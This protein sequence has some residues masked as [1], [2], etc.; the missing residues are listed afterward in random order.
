MF[1]R[2]PSITARLVL[3][4]LVSVGLMTLD[5]R[6]GVLQPVRYTLSALIYPVHLTAELPSMVQRLFA[7]EV[8]DRRD[9]LAEIDRLRDKLLLNRARLQKLD[10]L[11]VENIRLRKLL[12]ASY[13]VGES[14]LIAE[15]M[16][17]DFDPH[18]HLVRI[19]K[20]ATD[21]L[22]AGQPVLDAEGVVGQVNAVGPFSATVRLVSDPSHAIPVQVNRN[23]VRAVAVGTGDLNA[24]KLI[25]L[26]NNSDVRAGDLLL[27]SGL[28]GRF[29]AGYPVGKVAEVDT[30]PGEPFARVS[31]DPEAALD[32]IQEVLLVRRDEE[33]PH[34]ARGEAGR[35]GRGPGS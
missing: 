31:V 24:L 15:L 35:P 17:V 7:R 27:T 1:A 26:P 5:H 21:G 32:R 2:G 25:N 4:V 18:T 8:R 6:E 3:L 14:V 11:E 20:G 16:R 33:A 13:E 22:F 19:D 23:G 12:D 28:G 29:P 10:A 30:D 9:L 34:F